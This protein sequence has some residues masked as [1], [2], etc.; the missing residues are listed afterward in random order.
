MKALILAGGLA[1]RLRPITHG[2]P[3]CLLPIEAER[4][5]FD[6]QVDALRASSVTDIIVVTG[7][8]ADVVESHARERHPDISFTFIF[9]EKYER[10]RAAHALLAAKDAVME[11]VIYLNSDLLCE[12]SVIRSVVESSYESVTAIMQNEW[13]EEEVNVVMGEG[14]RIKEIGKLIEQERSQGEFI[15]AT[16]LSLPFWQAMMSAIEQFGEEGEYQK[17][18]V[19]SMQE[20]INAGGEL[21]ALDLTGARALEIDTIED[22]TAAKEIWTRAV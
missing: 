7:Y 14:N 10:T 20:V 11:P 4:T 2:L 5:I 16:K 9:H 13:D 18:A 22:Y 19:D 21:Y 12:E 15:G 1:T 3:K 6:I 8:M 17:F